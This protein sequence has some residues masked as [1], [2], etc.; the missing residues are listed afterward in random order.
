MQGY[1]LAFFALAAGIINLFWKER[2]KWYIFA[3]LIGVASVTI[4]KEITSH[5]S[6]ADKKAE[7]KHQDEIRA[8]LTSELLSSYH[9]LSDLMFLVDMH[10]DEDDS[11]GNT[12]INSSKYFPFPIINGKSINKIVIHLTVNTDSTDIALKLLDQDSVIVFADGK[13]L[14]S[15][16]NIDLIDHTIDNSSSKHGFFREEIAPFMNYGII[17]PVGNPKLNMPLTLP[18]L[19]Q[20][21]S[22]EKQIGYIEYELPNDISNTDFMNF[23]KNMA[24]NLS[25]GF[26]GYVT[27]NDTL[28]GIAEANM[29]DTGF[30][31]NI[32]VAV[33]TGSI[34]YIGNKIK[35]ALIISDYPKLY[36]TEE[37]PM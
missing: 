14:Y 5:K 20:S 22:K 6:E 24:D 15:Y 36:F 12:F 32:Y 29:T 11:N 4:W 17:F 2:G 19:L 37:V 27:D 16:G 10:P 33:K 9:K 35:V 30:R 26:K 28:G 34:T 13:E 3:I 25:L 18:V 23:Q 21:L 1:I 31:P 8:R 7:Q